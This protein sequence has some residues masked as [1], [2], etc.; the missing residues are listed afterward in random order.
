MGHPYARSFKVDPRGVDLASRVKVAST[1]F[2]G[3]TPHEVLPCYTKYPN[4]AEGN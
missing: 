4:L 3:A 2:S 1:S